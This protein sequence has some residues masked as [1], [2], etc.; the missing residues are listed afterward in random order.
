MCN[1]AC[2]IRAIA[3]FLLLCGVFLTVWGYVL[4]NPNIE[5]HR[6]LLVVPY[7]IL[8]IF[9]ERTIRHIR[10]TCKC[11]VRTY[12]EEWRDMTE[13]ERQL[14]IATTWGKGA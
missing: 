11:S 2:R 6:Y 14:Y 9:G 12:R 7:P 5:V 10:N 8:V 4:A 3:W 1:T 13:S